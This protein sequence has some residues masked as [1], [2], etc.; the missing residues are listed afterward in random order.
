LVNDLETSP[1]QHAPRDESPEAAVEWEK[2]ETA[3]ASAGEDTHSTFHFLLRR[4]QHN[5]D[6]PTFSKH[7]VEI[8]Q[9]ASS[10][11][12]NPAS[13][14]ELANTILKDYSLT[15]KLLKLVNSSFYS[16]FAGKISTVS[17]AVVILG[18]E[19]VRLAAVS[20]MLFEHLQNKEQGHE[21]KDAAIRSFMSGMLAKDLSET[22]SFDKPEEAFICS[23]IH[24]LGRHLVLYY[25]PEEYGRISQLMA[26]KGMDEQAASRAVL[27][28]TYEEIGTGIAKVWNFPS[29]IV[30][31]LR[32]LKPGKIG[33]PKSNEDLLQKLAGFSNEICS[34]A[35][36]TDGKQRE[37]ALAALRRRFKQSIPVNEKELS[38][39]LVSA[40]EKVERHS[41]I[42]NLSLKRSKFLR[43][44]STLSAAAPDSASASIKEE[45]PLPQCE[46]SD[47]PDYTNLEICE[48][49][50][51]SAEIEDLESVLING[52]QEITNVLMGDYDINDALTMIL[53]TI[54][55][56]FGLSRVLLFVMDAAQKNMGAR[57]GFGKGIEELLHQCHVRIGPHGD[58]FNIS[59]SQNKD[60]RIDDANAPRIQ[61]GIPEWYR[62]TIGA[63]AFILLPIT[64]NN[65]TLG[66]IYADREKAGRVLEGNQLNLIRTLRNQAV[67][68]IKQKH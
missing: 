18:F 45:K 67:L 3:G 32:R 2:M 24:N 57:F 62:Q 35:G 31:S 43:G 6:F 1:K 15:N 33:R 51:A 29:K 58:V 9:K 64:V 44:L 4:M 37:Q 42:L 19:Q 38:S 30:N 21:L 56:G 11:Q 20:L 49:E 13:A 28:M 53:E 47:L 27:G 68:A 14:S 36:N 55:R 60:L 17:R 40:R 52:I 48:P 65:K 10:A 59:V 66:L 61:K 22:V 7:A 50:A 26:Q 8:N 12:L 41:H 5:S 25:F 63:P 16:Q 39:M 34:I 54:Y 46:N 23:M